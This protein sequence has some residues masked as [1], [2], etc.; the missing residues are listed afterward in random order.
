MKMF[1]YLPFK[2]WNRQDYSK[3]FIDPDQMP[4]NAADAAEYDIWSGS[5]L[6]ATHPAV[7]GQI[8]K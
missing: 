4:L 8:N 6:S 2:Y 5:T 1:R 3:Q 7:L